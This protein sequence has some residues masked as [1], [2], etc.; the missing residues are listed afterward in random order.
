MA[1]APV[2]ASGLPG[3][4]LP[5]IVVSFVTSLLCATALYL[6]FVQHDRSLMAEGNAATL[7]AAESSGRAV[8]RT[9][10][11]FSESLL[12]ERLANVQQAL[13]GQALPSNLLDAAVITDDNFIV[14]ARNPAAIGRQLQDP[15]WLAAR[16][17]RMGSVSRGVER[18][19][20]A[21]IVIEPLR[22]QERIIGWVRFVFASPQEVATMRSKGD[23]ARDVALVVL[24]IFVL[25]TALLILT[26]R[27]LMSQVRSLIG[28]ILLDAMGDARDHSEETVELSK[29]G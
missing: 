1:Y 16:K 13:E 14:A 9:F 7:A 17:S 23:L 22:Q 11:S 27:G 3:T 28:R 19:G 2:N 4:W 10:A 29:A 18:G 20:Q 15:G 12:G 25:L 8:A 26:L 5:A 24:P 6:L 21:L